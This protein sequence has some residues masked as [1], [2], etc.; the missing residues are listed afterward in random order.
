MIMPGDLTHLLTSLRVENRYDLH[1]RYQRARL[2]ELKYGLDHHLEI[3]HFSSK[4]SQ[5]T[6]LLV[7]PAKEFSLLLPVHHQASCSPK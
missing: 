6:H 1:P 5:Q 3:I 2:V 4:R 7:S